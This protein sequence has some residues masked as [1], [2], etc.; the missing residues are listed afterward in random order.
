MRRIQK[1]IQVTMPTAM[2]DRVP[3]TIS[4]ALKESWSTT[5]V[6]TVKT[7]TTS[8]RAVP[9]PHHTNRISRRRPDL[10]R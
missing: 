4:W 3:P 1:I 7:A 9:T 10:T 8:A 5:R 6:M 2:I